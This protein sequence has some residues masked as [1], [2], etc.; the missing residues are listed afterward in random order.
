MDPAET[1]QSGRAPVDQLMAVVASQNGTLS[2]H[3]QL[4]TSQEAA[5]DRHDQHLGKIL[6]A[7]QALA[8]SQPAPTPSAPSPLAILTNLLH[9]L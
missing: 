1:Q 7:M 4:L 2:R 5:V 8:A 3:K 9:K 6:Q